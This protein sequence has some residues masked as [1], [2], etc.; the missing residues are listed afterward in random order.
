MA[1]GFIFFCLAC[2]LSFTTGTQVFKGQR[3]SWIMK[4][5]LKKARGE[6]SRSSSSCASGDDEDDVSAS[7]ESEEDRRARYMEYP[8]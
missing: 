8:S 7:S 4:V 1:M 6:F 3:N 5:A 2:G